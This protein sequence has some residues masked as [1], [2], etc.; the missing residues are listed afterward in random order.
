MGDTNLDV[1]KSATNGD[2]GETASLPAEREPMDRMEIAKVVAMPLVTL[3]V[4]SL[5]SYSL[6]SR[7][8]ADQNSRLYA[9]MMSRREESDSALRKDMFQSILTTFLKK[10]DRQP[11]AR[12]LEQEV[13][14]IELLAYNFHESLDLGPLFKHVQRDLKQTHEAIDENLLWRVEKVAK[15]VKGQ[16]LAVL[17][18][19]GSVINGDLD[20]ETMNVTFEQ[21]TVEPSP[22]KRRGGPTLCTAINS[23]HGETHW[24]QFALSFLDFNTERRE[25]EISVAVSKPLLEKDCK[26]ILDAKTEADNLEARAQFWVGLFAFPMIDSTHLTHSERCAVS[27]TDIPDTKDTKFV[28]IAISFFQASRASLKDKPYYD[29]ILHDVFGAGKTDAAH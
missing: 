2:G 22:G 20:T 16:Q 21:A 18:D 23:G 9:D 1:D 29:E 6:S 7:Q 3:I 27:V 10:D 11:H 8:E 24:R 13:L 25:V 26:T 28:K 14:N 12:D 19:T 17:A 15:E 5:F 4:G